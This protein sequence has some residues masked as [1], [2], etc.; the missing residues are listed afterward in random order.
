MHKLQNIFP[1]IGARISI[2]SR[3][4]KK[5]GNSGKQN[6]PWQC[7]KCVLRYPSNCNEIA[8]AKFRIQKRNLCNE[9][10]IKDPRHMSSG[11][12]TFYSPLHLCTGKCSAFR[13]SGFHKFP[14]TSVSP[15]LRTNF[16]VFGISACTHWKPAW[17]DPL[18]WRNESIIWYQNSGTIWEVPLKKGNGKVPDIASLF[19]VDEIALFKNMD[20]N[21]SIKELN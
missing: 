4:K 13:G 17:L 19:I 6:H 10:K 20:T 11:Y 7:H 21:V 3:H 18:G 5:N 2:Q 15:A 1:H 14:S 12:R 8:W 9:E 16:K